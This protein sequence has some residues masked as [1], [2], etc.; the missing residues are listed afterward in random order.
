MASAPFHRSFGRRRSK[1]LWKGALAISGVYDLRPLV[2][3][4]FLQPDLRLDEASAARVSPALM[5]PATRCPV[6]TCVG[7]DESSE[8]H[9]QNALIGERWRAAFAGDIPMPGTHHFSV[10]DGL[11]EQA[12]PLF[13]GLRKLMKLDQ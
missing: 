1:D 10:L 5:T 9:R 13:A 2:E 6:M 7:G 8:F 4:D 3:V 12:S 11:A